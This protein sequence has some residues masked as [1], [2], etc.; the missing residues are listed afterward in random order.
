MRP[1]GGRLVARIVEG[2]E[3]T[4]HAVT[5]DGTEPLPRNWPRLLHEGNFAGAWSALMNVVTAV[6]LIGLLVTGPWIWLRRRLR[7]RTRGARKVAAA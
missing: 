6:A 4:L 7:Q 2:G 1:L 5:R 3:Y